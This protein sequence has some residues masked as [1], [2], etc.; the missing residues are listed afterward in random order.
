MDKNYIKLNYSRIKDE[1]VKANKKFPLKDEECVGLSQE[2]GLIIN[3]CGTYCGN[4]EDYGVVCDG[5]R[6]RNGEPIWYY[7]YSRKNPCEHF[8]C[9]EE[10]QYHDCSQCGEMPCSKFFEYPDPDM[11]DE[12]KQYW[13]KLRMENFNKINSSHHIE[14]KDTFKENEETY[15]RK[16]K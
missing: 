10:K 8:T 1:F 6:N 2:E 7:L 3:S 12:F 13:F 9:C 15:C 14:I 16:D 5:C 4:C 11:S